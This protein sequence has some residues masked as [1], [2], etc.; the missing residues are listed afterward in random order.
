[1]TWTLRS[2]R[3]RGRSTA[4][5]RASVRRCLL[6][7]TSPAPSR[8]AL[9]PPA[10]CCAQCIALVRRPNAVVPQVHCLQCS[11]RIQCPSTPRHQP[12]LGRARWRDQALSALLC[13]QIWLNYVTDTLNPRAGMVFGA[14][15]NTKNQVDNCCQAVSTAVAC[16]G[17][18]AFFKVLLHT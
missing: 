1:M 6:Q 13:C 17:I 14:S 7:R 12:A 2:L 9:T 11:T 15:A 3:T 16:I 18:I 5:Q 8:S 10:R 4:R